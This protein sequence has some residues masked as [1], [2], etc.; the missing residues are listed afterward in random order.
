LRQIAPSCLQKQEQS[1]RTS[2]D[3]KPV[4]I[5]FFFSFHFSCDFNY[6]KCEQTQKK[7]SGTPGT[8]K[9]IKLG[10]IAY[11]VFISAPEESICSGRSTD[12]AS[13]YI[14]RLPALSQ[15]QLLQRQLHGYWD[16]QGITPCSLLS[17]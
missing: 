15:W 17:I 9:Q 4:G 2:Q 14:Q 5:S 6:Q 12:F 11:A 16:S 8:V 10:N 13:S 1:L 7:P 3:K